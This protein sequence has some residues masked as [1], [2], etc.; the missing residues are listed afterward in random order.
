MPSYLMMISTLMMMM[1]MMMM[2]VLLEKVSK[3]DPL[4]IQKK[5]ITD[6]KLQTA[7]D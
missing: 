3:S 1:M 5:K 6:T 7:L 4:E 2:I